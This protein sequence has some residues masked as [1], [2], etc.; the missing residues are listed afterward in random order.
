MITPYTV[1]I[2]GSGPAGLS[3]AAHAARLGLNHI[4]L[5]AQPH[6]ADTIYKYQKGKHVMAEP[7]YLDL[8]SPMSFAAGTRESILNKWD[9]EIAA[10]GA[11]IQ[12]RAAVSA[13]Q[14]RKGCFWITLEST[15][16]IC[17]EQIVLAIGMQGNLRALGVPGENLPNVQYQLDDPRAY[18]GE[19]I[20]VVG[21]GDAAI[22][23]ALAL[24]DND[25]RVILL[26][27]N[28]EFSRCKEGNL[29]AIQAAVRDSRLAVRYRTSI[30][31]VD[32]LEAPAGAPVMRA[33]T[34][35]TMLLVR[36]CSP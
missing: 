6:L 14:G 16:L 24:A 15:E 36:S 4:L 2:I 32:A 7:A 23:N 27:R 28:E 12:H 22:E 25:N 29:S 11:V 9:D 17:A 13:I 26:N 19:T 10:L 18:G 8:R 21:A 3:A 33:S 35:C 34:R 1:A 31:H 5:E 30:D 20:V